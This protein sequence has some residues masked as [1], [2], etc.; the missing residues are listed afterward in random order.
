MTPSE[1]DQ[2]RHMRDAAIA[3]VEFSAGKSRGDLDTDQMLTFALTRA[4]AGETQPLARGQTTISSS[5]SSAV[6]FFGLLSTLCHRP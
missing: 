5:S 4:V 6:Y 3:S 2:L 1:T